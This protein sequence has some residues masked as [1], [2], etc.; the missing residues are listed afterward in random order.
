MGWIVV[1]GFCDDCIMSFVEVE[2]VGDVFG[3]VL[4]LYI[5]LI[6]YYGFVVL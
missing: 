6:V 4:D 3:Y 5:E 1:L 2:I